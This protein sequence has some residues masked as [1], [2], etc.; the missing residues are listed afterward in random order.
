[1]HLM[2]SA[3][4]NVAEHLL[5]L[6]RALRIK[7]DDSR[8]R[9]VLLGTAF[10]D[11]CDAHCLSRTTRFGIAVSPAGPIRCTRTIR[12]AQKAPMDEAGP[13]PLRRF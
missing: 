8:D 1:V 12:C 13:S 3:A 6:K 2:W 11:A 4:R 9:R 7:V 10:S 5:M